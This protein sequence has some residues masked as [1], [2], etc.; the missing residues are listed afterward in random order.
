MKAKFSELEPCPYRYGI[1][2]EG[3]VLFECRYAGEAYD[4]E[5][6]ID[7]C[8]NFCPLKKFLKLLTKKDMWH[9]YINSKH[10]ISRDGINWTLRG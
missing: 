3:R 10:A 8:S 4:I 9:I 5:E 6:M 1:V 7:I 2:E